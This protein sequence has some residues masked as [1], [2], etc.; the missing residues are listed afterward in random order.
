MF[1]KTRV[2]GR[3]AHPLYRALKRTKDDAGLAGPIVWNFEKFLI[4]PDGTRR[5]FRPSVAPDDPAIVGII[6]EQL[7]AAV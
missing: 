2:N 1:E 3:H 5:R 6:E 7:G 4:L